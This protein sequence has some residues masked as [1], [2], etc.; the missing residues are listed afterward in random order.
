MTGRRD[1]MEEAVH[2]SKGGHGCAG[3]IQNSRASAV[4][5]ASEPHEANSSIVQ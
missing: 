1:K 5:F 4:E 2:E 3:C